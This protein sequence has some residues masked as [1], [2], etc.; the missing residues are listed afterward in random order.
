M[1]LTEKNDEH[2]DVVI[3][4][5]LVRTRVMICLQLVSIESNINNVE[6][7]RERVGERK[8]DY[9]FQSVPTV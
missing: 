4:L 7:K 6:R 1:T 5:F 9:K 8:R 3:G 2:T